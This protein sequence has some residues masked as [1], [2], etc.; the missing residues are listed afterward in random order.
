[1]QFNRK[2]FFDGYR[3]TFGPM[4]RE[5]V[6]G[7]E[8]LLGCIEN[9]K[10]I[11]D[12]RDASY[13]LSTV[14]HETA[15]TFQPIHEYGSKSYFIKR[16][17]GQTR[18]G[19]E[20]GNDTPEEGYYYAGKGDTQTTGESNYERAEDA[21]RKEYPEVV[22]EFEARTGRKFDLTVGDQP[23]DENDPQNMMDPSISYVAM[24][25]G[26][27]TGMFTGKKLRDF[28][29]SR[30]TDYVGCRK[31]VNGRDKAALIAGYAR[32]F[33]EIL[34][35]ATA[36]SVSEP[37]ET[38]N[39]TPSTT[40]T[41]PAQ[42]PDD[43]TSPDDTSTQPPTSNENVVVEKEAPPIGFWQGKKL[44]ITGWFT[45]IGGTAA[46]QQY[47][48]DFESLGIPMGFVKYAILGLVGA[49]LVWLA[50]CGISHLLR[51]VLSRWLT[52]SLVK[53]NETPTNTVIVASP[54][55][56]AELEAAGWTVIR[57]Q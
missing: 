23:N 55:R 18:K 20:L 1:M 57:R 35:S 49:F 37:V 29:N 27:R 28:I 44:Q 14:K 26:M 16:Y 9:D 31:V 15:N 5:Q 43:Q 7:L 30:G 3:K 41:D 6:N 12:I 45:S 47:K 8:R 48:A 36:A 2:I 11:R 24:S 4:S 32:S 10:Y 50:Y 53:A 38:T 40:A 46:L 19:K 21:I 39:D 22:A 34:K 13:I 42:S 52:A 51:P 17:G 25:Y 33:E 54:D 56:L